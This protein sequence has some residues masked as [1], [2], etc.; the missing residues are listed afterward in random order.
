MPFT[1]YH[2]GPGSGIGMIFLKF[3]DFPTLFITS[4]IVDLEPLCVLVFNLNYPLHGF[5]HSFLG[6]SILAVLTASVVY[7]LRKFIQRIMAVFKLK[8]DTSFKKILW[9]AFF[10]IYLHIILDSFL[11]TDIKPFYPLDVNPFYGLFSTV[12]INY[13]CLLL[14][15]VGVILYL[16]RLFFLKDKIKSPKD[17]KAKIFALIIIFLLVIIAIISIYLIQFAISTLP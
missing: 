3:F 12:Q 6:G 2:W 1:P 16:V 4:V 10:G 8:Q 13:F 15:G 9:T 17:K 7:F 11:Y 14:M 5:F